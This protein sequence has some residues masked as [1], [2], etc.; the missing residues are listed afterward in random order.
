MNNIRFKNIESQHIK[1]CFLKALVGYPSLASRQIVVIQR[2]VPNST[3]R[4]QPIIDLSFWKKSSRKFKVEINRFTSIDSKI[5]LEDLEEKV[6]VGWFAHE[7]GHIIDYIDRSALGLI[8]FA[9]GYLLFSNFRLGAERRADLYAIEHG[10]AESIVETKKFILGQS[11]LPN[12]YKKR[13]ERYYM[14]ADEVALVL[15]KKQD[16]ALAMDQLI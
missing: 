11:S 7:L 1:D 10:F 16:E 8:Q 3:M 2:H 9:I 5:K 4:A 6:L 15:K 14:S 12:A 13:I